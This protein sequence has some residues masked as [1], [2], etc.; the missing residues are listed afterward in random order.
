VALGNLYWHAGWLEEGLPLLE[1]AVELATAVG[2]PGLLGLAE[3]RRGLFLEHLGRHDEGLDAY[4]R[5]IPLLEAAGDLETLTRTFNNRALVYGTRGQLAE[6]WSDLERALEAARGLGDPAQIGWALGMLATTRWWG[7]GD[8]PRARPYVEELLRLERQ[9][10]G[11]RASSFVAVAVGLQLL[12][13]SDPSA[14]DHLERLGAAAE[15][16]GDIS[17]WR[18]VQDVLAQWDLIQGNGKRALA[19]YEVLQEDLRIE[20][21]HRLELDRKLAQASL[22]CGDLERA[23]LLVSRGMERTQQPG[24]LFG[25]QPW[26]TLRGQLRTAQQRWAEAKSDF[27]EALRLARAHHFAFGIADTAQSYGE[28]LARKG[29]LEAAQ[30]RFEEALSTFRR[31]NAVPYAK[32]VERALAE[33]G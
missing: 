18:A 3:S 4:S 9:I 13:G 8:W 14:L 15:Q 24:E 6:A 7:D 20:S 25:S 10:R 17:L 23:E 27:E 28:M 32:R 21:Q 12:T 30:Q 26:L 19:R 33:L 5:S 31:M 11:T 2:D 22:A 16:A 29:E 1:R